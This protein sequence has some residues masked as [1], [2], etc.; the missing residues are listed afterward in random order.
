M[1]NTTKIVDLL[2]EI[3]HRLYTRGFVTA[4]D[5]NVS[6]RL[7]NGN[8]LITRTSINKGM[9]KS[10]DLIEVDANGNPVN[11][12]H[13]SSPIIYK[14]STEIG[15]HLFIYSKRPNINA[16]VHA[17]PPYATGFAAAGQSITASILPEVVIDLGEIPLASYAT[18]S[19]EE[20]TNSIAPFVSTANAILLANHGVVT[21][22]TNLNGAYFKM[23]KV[24]HAA[25]IIFVARMLGG[26]K[27]LKPGD[28]E[29]L[30][31]ISKS[32]YGKDFSG[33]SNTEIMLETEILSLYYSAD[34][35]T[36]ETVREI[37]KGK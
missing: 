16:I 1:E 22:D 36:R 32:T 2:V 20:I 3:C 4:M 9:V 7:E 11:T 12:A 17:H 35:K 33:K 26:A 21:Y 37:L 15:M 29:K 13:N 18:P 14:P 19:T 24:E 5:G 8:F 23:E 10:N 6:V 28:I 25:Q 30:H 31:A 27:Y 34:E